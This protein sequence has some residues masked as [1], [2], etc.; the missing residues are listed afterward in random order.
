MSR[1]RHDFGERETRVAAEPGYRMCTW[2]IDTPDWDGRRVAGRR[3]R[4]ARR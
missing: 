3:P 4:S 2:T 1:Q